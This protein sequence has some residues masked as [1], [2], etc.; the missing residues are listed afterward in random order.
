[1]SCST[2]QITCVAL[3]VSEQRCLPTMTYNL[4]MEPF[5]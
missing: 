1:M 3:S 4:I 2:T 5:M